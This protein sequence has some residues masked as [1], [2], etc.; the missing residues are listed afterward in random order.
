MGFFGDATG[1]MLNSLPSF[2]GLSL[3]PGI[4]GFVFLA[5]L[6]GVVTFYFANKRAYCNTIEIL[7]EINGITVPL[8]LDKAREVTL[9]RTSVRAFLLKKRKF[10]LPRPSIQTGKQNYMFFIRKDGEWVNVGYSNLNEEMKALKLNYDHTDMRMANASLKRLVD[11]SYKKINWIKEY[12]PYIAIGI[13][14]LLLGISSYI[15]TK[16]MG[17]VASTFNAASTSNSL[18]VDDLREILQ[19]MD[20]ICASSGVRIVT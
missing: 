5:I 13:L 6:V 14:V 9:P 19:T 10:Y 3:I 18:I 1:G 4:V 12:A 17:T 20:N 11:D 2:G 8:G 7:G 15:N 16:E